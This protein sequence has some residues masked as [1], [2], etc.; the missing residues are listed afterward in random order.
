MFEFR[1]RPNF[2]KEATPEFLLTELLNNLSSLAEDRDEV[3]T[4]VQK[5]LQDMCARFEAP[6]SETHGKP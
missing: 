1:K 4:R 6:L 2:P 5:K 3:R